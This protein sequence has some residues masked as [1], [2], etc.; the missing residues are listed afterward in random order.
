MF[1]KRQP[2]PPFSPDSFKEGLDLLLGAATRAG[3]SVTSIADALA[4]K[5]KDLRAQSAINASLGTT[6]TRFDCHGRPIHEEPGVFV[7][8]RRVA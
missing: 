1:G 4:A 7:S 3:M 8:G 5:T 6:R 2:T